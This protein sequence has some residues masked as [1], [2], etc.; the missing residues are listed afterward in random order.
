MEL[1]T[2]Q[3]TEVP[4]LGFGT[5]EL[6]GDICATATEAALELG[7]RYVDTAQA[8]G[9]EQLVGAAITAAPVDRSEIFLTTKVWNDNLRHPDKVRESV[10][11]SLHKLNTEYVDLMMLHWPVELDRL[12][13]NLDALRQ[14][15]E[16]DKI[17][18]LG[19]CNFTA[20]QTEHA[21]ELAPLFSL[22]V[23]HHPYLAQPAL[24]RLAGERDLLFTAY[25]P[26]GRGDVLTDDVVVAIA[27]SHGATPA[28]VVLRYLLDEEGP[29]AV[30]PKASTREHAEDN[31]AALAVRLTDDDRAAIAALDRDGR[32]IDPPWA[33][34]WS[35]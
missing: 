30:I 21:L 27:E 8:Y 33:P 35:A 16:Q 3:G 26:L 20:T 23:E 7:Y 2:V 11:E 14:L 5:W 1:V 29:V 31:L 18:F 22:Q 34:D 15:Q 4:A 6:E 25:S 17:R 9:N 19:V 32:I 28:Q 13:A 10:H 24:I 12:G